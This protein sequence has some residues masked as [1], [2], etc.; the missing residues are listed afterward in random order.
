MGDEVYYTGALGFQRPKTYFTLSKMRAAHSSDREQVWVDNDNVCSKERLRVLVA[1]LERRGFVCDLDGW[2]QFL[3]L[4][5]GFPG[6]ASNWSCP[7]ER[8]QR[9]Q[10]DGVQVKGGRLSVTTDVG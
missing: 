1:E 3:T 4:R 5:V 7:T 6:D 2:N 10:L 8:V 9:V